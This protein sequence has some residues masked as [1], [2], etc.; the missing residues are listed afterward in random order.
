MLFPFLSDCESGPVHPESCA[1]SNRQASP[2]ETRDGCGSLRLHR[3]TPI[4]VMLMATAV[5]DEGLSLLFG[6]ASMPPVEPGVRLGFAR[7]ASLI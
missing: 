7:D 5:D 4:A 3:S 6:I 1:S 2:A